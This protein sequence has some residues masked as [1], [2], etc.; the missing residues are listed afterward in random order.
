M[1]P[2]L[3]S[4]QLSTQGASMTCTQ[5]KLSRLT[6]MAMVLGLVGMACSSSGLNRATDAAISGNGGSNPGGGTTGAGGATSASTGVTGAG[7]ATGTSTSVAGAGG[8]TTTIGAGGGTTTIGAGGSL[9][10]GG[11]AETGITPEP[12]APTITDQMAT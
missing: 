2:S 10:D 8:G 1:F 4:L 9:T 12:G 5:R 6:A 11:G 3:T 7:G